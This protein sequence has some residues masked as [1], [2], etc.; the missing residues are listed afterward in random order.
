MR[1]LY[2]RLVAI[3]E[4]GRRAVIAVDEAQGLAGGEALAE[5]V[6]MLNF[7]YEDARSVGAA[8]RLAGAGAADGPRAG[9]ARPLRA[10]RAAGAARPRRRPAYLAHRLLTAGGDP[11][12]FAPEVADA[13]AERAGGLPRRMNA[14]ADATLFE[15]HLARRARPAIADV[16]RAARDLPWAQSSA[17]TVSGLAPGAVGPGEEKDDPL[18][19][20]AARASVWSARRARALASVDAPE[21]DADLGPELIDDI[22]SSLNGGPPGGARDPDYGLDLTT[23]EPELDAEVLATTGPDQTAPGAWS[24]ARPAAERPAPVPDESEIDGLFVDLVDSEKKG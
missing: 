20:P 6:A 18:P 10:A 21:I 13:V 16:K 2:E 15:A 14:L 5:L 17:D 1:Q 7:E 22:E 23:R 11:A 24:R 19:P 12:L 4:E 8:H 9:A 3:R